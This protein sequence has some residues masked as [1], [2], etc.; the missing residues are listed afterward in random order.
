MALSQGVAEKPFESSFRSSLSAFREACREASE[1]L[2][3]LF[4]Q[5]FEWVCDNSP[6]S[7]L[8]SSLRALRGAY[9]E[10]VGRPLP[11]S[12]GTD[13]VA[14][15]AG[16]T[17]AARLNGT[18]RGL[19]IVCAGVTAA[20][21]PNTALRDVVSWCGGREQRCVPVR[22]CVHLLRRANFYDGCVETACVFFSVSRCSK[23][24]EAAGPL[25]PPNL[26]SRQGSRR[27]SAPGSPPRK[28]RSAPHGSEVCIR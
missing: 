22:F 5:L 16:G 15:C 12:S 18:V 11:F 14:E 2:W 13:F 23:T 28:R 19:V 1:G 25:G 6:R 7:A 21:R 3:Q 24:G 26:Q 17:S 9:R 27:R 4:E 8:T 20:A 10:G